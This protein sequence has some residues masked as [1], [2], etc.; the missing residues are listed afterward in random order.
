MEN[1]RYLHCYI[2]LIPDLEM[3]EVLLMVDPPMASQVVM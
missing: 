3:W 1:L 2:L